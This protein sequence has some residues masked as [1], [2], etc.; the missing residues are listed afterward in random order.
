MVNDNPVPCAKC[1]HPAISHAYGNCRE[2]AQAKAQQDGA[3][4]ARANGGYATAPPAHRFVLLADATNP[5]EAARVRE[6]DRRNAY[7]TWFRMI[8]EQ[9]A[10][11]H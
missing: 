7:E 5:D 9:D 3:P 6:E 1:G 2:C 11:G 8:N 10:R 4:Q